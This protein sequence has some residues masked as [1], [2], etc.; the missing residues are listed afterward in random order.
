MFR[1]KL[2]YFRGLDGC[3][4]H[5]PVGW[6]KRVTGLELSSELADFYSL[7]G[8]LCLFNKSLFP[9]EIVGPAEFEPANLAILGLGPQDDRSDYW[10]IVATS[11]ADQFVSIDL[12][13]E[14]MGRC[15]DSYIDRH[16]VAG[17]C[18]V[19]AT[20]FADF[21]EKTIAYGGRGLYWLD[22]Q[23]ESLGDAYD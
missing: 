14:R 9:F 12:H 19:V 2:E 3:I 13:P 1:N 20:S 11:G 22:P 21:L 16:A 23:F 4:V 10:Y 17:S 6:P 8:G 15:Y 7:C 18:S 5:S